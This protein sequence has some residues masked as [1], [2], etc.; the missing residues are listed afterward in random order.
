M[1]SKTKEKVT[2]E[3]EFTV[4]NDVNFFLCSTGQ[5]NDVYNFNQTLE[6]NYVTYYI[7]SK[8]S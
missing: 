8:V 1:V 4:S 5:E 6:I 2:M 7:N 3:T